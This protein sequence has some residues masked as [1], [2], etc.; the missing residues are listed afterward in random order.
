MEARI[1]APR[2]LSSATAAA[3]IP[4]V[5]ERVR[6][7]GARSRASASPRGGD[8]QP[9]E[10]PHSSLSECDA[11]VVVVPAHA[12]VVFSTRTGAFAEMERFPLARRGVKRDFPYFKLL[13]AVVSGI[14]GRVPRSPQPFCRLDLHCTRPGKPQL[15]PSLPLEESPG[16][17]ALVGGWRGRPI[18]AL[19]AACPNEENK[20]KMVACFVRH[21]PFVIERCRR[22][23][24]AGSEQYIV[25]ATDR[26]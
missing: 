3:D 20:K 17:S 15:F 11:S 2:P 12:A 24:Q 23:T 4:G 6:G 13:A 25:V 1:S 9:R 8:A 22:P 5:G 10:L 21:P 14:V 19:F 18:I 16:G 7:A 26:G